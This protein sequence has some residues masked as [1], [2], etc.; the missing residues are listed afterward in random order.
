[1]LL[2]FLEREQVGAD[3]FADG[4]VRAATCF[5]GA[6]ARWCERFVPGEE[7]GVFS[8]LG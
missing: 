4:G 2:E 3:V 7:F 1:L 8:V 5:N 6:D